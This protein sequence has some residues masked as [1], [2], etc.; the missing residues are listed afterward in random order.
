[1]ASA[2]APASPQVLVV[3]GPAGGTGKT[4][5]AVLMGYMYAAK[6]CA[7]TLVDL[8]QYGAVAPWLQI[9]RGLSS[10]VAGL[11]SGL[12]E[13]LGMEQR[14][15]SALMPAPGAEERLQILPSSGA[16]KMDQVKASDVEALCRLLTGLSQVV[17]VDTSSELTDR[18]LGALTAATR[19]VLTVTPEVVPGW[20]ALELLELLR[21]AYIRRDNLTVAF[22]RVRPGCRFG[23]DDYQQVLGLPVAG[24]IPES[25]DLRSAVERGR[26]PAA[27]N[28]GPGMDAV[29]QLAHALVPIF[30]HKELSRRWP[31]ST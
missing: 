19:I 22:N 2:L 7:T 29:R 3:H 9:P 10:G 16:A 20:Q 6:G 18:T 24:I 4:L 31:W 14:L 13:N 28:K 8:S 30:T 5:L 27:R 23:V 15:R 11:V 1:M 17:I 21:S 26:P 25:A 12:H